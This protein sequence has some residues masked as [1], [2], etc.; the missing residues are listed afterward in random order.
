MMTNGEVLSSSMFDD[1]VSKGFFCDV[2]SHI[3]NLT[4]SSNNVSADQNFYTTS[5]DAYHGARED[6]STETGVSASDDTALIVEARPSPMELTKTKDTVD[7]LV[8]FLQV[9][10][11]YSKTFDHPASL[12]VMLSGL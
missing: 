6:L 1:D 4:L 8:K 5:R 10:P 3:A 11:V 2:L 9:S 7:V 12:V